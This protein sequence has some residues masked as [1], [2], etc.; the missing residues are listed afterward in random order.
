MQALAHLVSSFDDGFRRRHADGGHEEPGQRG[1][2]LTRG[3]WSDRLEQNLEGV[4]PSVLVRCARIVLRQLA[5]R[6]ATVDVFDVMLTCPDMG[7][8]LE[9]R[10]HK[11]PTITN[12]ASTPIILSSSHL[13]RRSAG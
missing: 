10:S 12:Y 7:P 11:P 13:T 3:G 2:V 9:D 4:I 8:Q 1:S 5:W 6:L